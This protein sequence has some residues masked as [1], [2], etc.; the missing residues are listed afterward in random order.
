[1]NNPIISVIVPCFNHEKYVELCIRSIM[2][3]SYKNF[4]LIVFD[5]G[6]KDSSPIILK[7]LQHEF[8]FQLILQKNIGLAATLNKGLKE[9]AKGKYFTLCA[10][11][12][13]WC[14]DKL[15]LQVEFME[16]NPD[17]PMCFG[18]VHYI[19]EQSNII[20]QYDIQNNVLRGGHIFDDIFTFKLHPPVVYL[21]RRTIFEE[22]GY[23]NPMI[24]AEDYYMNLKIAS[25]YKIGFID[26]YL[27]Y[28]R[29]DSD[30]AKVIRFEKVSESHLMAIEGYKSNPNYKKVKRI[31][32]LR[33]FSVFAF[34][35]EHK[36]RA[37]LNAWKSIGLFYK[38][39]YIISCARLIL[40][41][42]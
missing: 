6:S 17:I 37:L 24:F 12:D 13:Y 28:Y 18:K 38:K 10:S 9:F 41:W 34:Y 21:Y 7:N 39:H 31:V 14:I 35:K 8:G 29:V 11:D 25:K 20:K 16:K 1:M 4:E 40:I 5:D 42:K 32:Y 33:K 2:E 27:G 36:G 30:V 23:F 26:E 15:K 19:D 3:Q 22:I